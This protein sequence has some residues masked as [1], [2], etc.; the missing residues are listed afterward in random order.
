M[1]GS[2]GELYTA[3]VEGA[4]LTVCE[5]CKKFGGVITKIRQAHLPTTK[6]PVVAEEE[7]IQIIVDDYFEKIRKRRADLGLRQKE[8]AKKIN[9]KES[10]I[11]KIESGHFEP[12]LELAKK[13][14][15]FLK[16]TIVEEYKENFEAQKAS[17]TDNFTIGDFIKIK[18]K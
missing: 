11:Q 4:E 10:V 17:K 9:E 15:R 6:T 2:G 16:I 18:Q 12:S 13:I 7:K 8:L 5:N 14:E 1:C 3:N